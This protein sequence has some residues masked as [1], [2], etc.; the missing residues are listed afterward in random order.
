MKSKEEIERDDALEELKKY[1]SK[2][3]E[4]AKAREEAE[5]DK[6]VTESRA[7]LD[8][9]ISDALKDIS[10]KPSKA[11]VKRLASYMLMARNENLNLSAKDLAGIV[12][13]DMINEY[14]E[15]LELS[16]DDTFANLIG[17]KNLTRSQKI[18]LAK[19]RKNPAENVQSKNTSTQ[20]PEKKSEKI[21]DIHSFLKENLRG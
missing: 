10:L 19:M 6:L 15:Q 9:E 13:Q 2:E 3:E 21:Y 17:E 7:T 16:D 4:T 20:V 5:F 8:K 1:K 18:A 11:T 14:M 12:K